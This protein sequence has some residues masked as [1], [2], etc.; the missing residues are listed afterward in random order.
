MFLIGL[1]PIVFTSKSF[2][3]SIIGFS[4]REIKQIIATI[5]P[6]FSIPKITPIQPEKIDLDQCDEIPS[7]YGIPGFK[8]GIDKNQ[9]FQ[10]F[11]TPA[12]IETGYWPNTQA[13]FYHLIPNRVSLG[14]LFDKK[15]GKLRQTEAAFSQEVELKTILITFNSMSG[16]R[17]N[18]TLESGLKMVYNRKDNDYS[19]A[20]D[21][22]KGI[23]ERQ[24]SD[25]IY[26]GIWE[27]DLH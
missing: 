19:F 8:P 11:G 18:S 20:I 6:D 17:L 9:V 23:V 7:G 1:L 22:L 24:Q 16:C 26:I 14:F 25:R 15:S 3:P 13:V 27:T 21:S 2:Y 10:M 12:K 4:S 5:I